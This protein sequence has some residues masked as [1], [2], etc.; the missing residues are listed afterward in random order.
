MAIRHQI[1]KDRR[2]HDLMPYRVR[3]ILLVSSPYDAFIL[4]EDG[5]LTEQVFFEYRDV[6]LSGPPRVTHAATG[7][8]A[9]RM[10][11]TRRFD[12]IL[13]M[14]S[15]ADMGVNAFG[16]RVKKLRPGRPVVLLALDRKELDRASNLIDPKATDG[17][18]LWSGDSQILLAIIKYIEDKQNVDLDIQHGNVRVIIMIED[19]PR[20][21][22]SFLGMIYKELMTQSHSL[23][24]EGVNELHRRMYMR[25]RP[26]I[27][28]ATTY[29][30]GVE[31]FERYGDNVTAVITDVRIPR[32][33][34]LDPDGGLDFARYVRKYDPEFPVLLQSAE[35]EN[36]E[37]AEA[38]GATFVDKNSSSL[39]AHIRSFFR[40]KLGFGDF[41]FR[42]PDGV[43]LARAKDVRD[44]ERQ[45]AVI[46]EES[47]IYHASHNHFSIWL[48][49][50]SEFEAADRLRPRQISDF[51]SIEATREYLISLLRETQRIAHRGVISDFDRT[52]F[53]ETLFSRIGHGSL[54]GKARSI[55]FLNLNLANTDARDFGGVPIQI[56]KT[57]VIT[58]DKFV[59]LMDNNDLRDFAYSCEEDREI[60]KRFLE[61]RIADDLRSDLTF[62]AHHIEGPLA[63]RSSSL[64]ED[65][66][67]QPLAGIYNTLMIPNSSRDP[68]VRLREISNAVK[69]V[70]ASTFFQNAKSFLASTGNRVEEEMMGV[71]IQQ[72]I[73]RRYGDRFYP[74]FAGLAQ[75]R[76]YYPIG[77]Q[78]AE[79]GVVTLA[80]GLG[81]LVVEG[82]LALRFSPR[83]PQV[84]PQLATA[85]SIM[86][87]TQRGFFALDLER[88]SGD[89]IANLYS[90]VRFYDLKDAEE[91]GTLLPVG[92]VFSADDQQLREDLTLP[93]PRIVSFSNI[94]KHKA[95]PLAEALT[96]VLEIAEQGLGSPV[97]VEFACDM[98]DWGRP[99][100]RGRERTHPG[101]YLLQVRPFGPRVASGDLKKVTYNRA[102]TL[103]SSDKCLGHGV[104]DS[105]RDIVYVRRDRWEAANNKA[106]AAEIGELNKL[107]GERRP[108]LV[109]GPGRWGTADPWLGIPVQWSQ[110]SNVRVMVEASPLGYD[111]EPSQGTHFFQNITSLR[112]GY[113]TLPP[114]AEKKKAD[115]DCFVDWKWLDRQPAKTETRYL[116]H[117]RLESPLTVVLDGREG[118]GV[119]L[120]PSK[121]TD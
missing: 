98:G 37:K 40:R 72:L 44:L 51:P 50:R 93:G 31:L 84:L 100:R 89:E 116:R 45:L 52:Q 66:L 46:P 49:A 1:L 10:L 24:S 54:G 110:I 102:Q 48:M 42:N 13:T 90:N 26:K 35:A 38:I 12:L 74:S 9:L 103:C 20:Y 95:V 3:E 105:I 11:K 92:S 83:H 43:E 77:P 39:L 86:D 85:K 79:D 80:L 47:L 7:E 60:A 36:E 113:L 94:L 57:V 14:T 59:E 15:L 104:E 118:E 114:G 62:I 32:G 115:G 81:R 63:I 64:L 88:D 121:K 99:T 30:E 107:L 68:E 23:Y 56:P 120:K 108:Y 22:S 117:L 33:G 96:S 69:L 27:L 19:S 73:G 87:S 71:I 53:D 106:I 34:L 55:A 8:D 65:S 70:Y 41:V 109:I 25:S 29:E 4:E 58:T 119:I 2:F 97:E 112:V 78:M 18:F 75:S 67:H 76:N 16:R 61:S 17:A 5:Q 101:L 6:S 21:Y 111:V 82:G 91:D 28:H